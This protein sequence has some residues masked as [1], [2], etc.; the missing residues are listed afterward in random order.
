M[1]SAT[2]VNPQTRKLC[3]PKIDS[4]FPINR[5][6][7]PIDAGISLPRSRDMPGAELE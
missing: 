3:A 7:S 4:R 6:H 2:E 5:L 1:V